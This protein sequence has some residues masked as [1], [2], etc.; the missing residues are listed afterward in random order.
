MKMKRAGIGGLF[1]L[2]FNSIFA[3]S[4]AA[5]PLISVAFFGEEQEWSI[6]YKTL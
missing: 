5:R 6:G 1:R 3:Q 2:G 4:V